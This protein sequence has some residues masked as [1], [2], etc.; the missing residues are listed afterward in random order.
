MNVMNIFIVSLYNFQANWKND[1]KFFTFQIRPKYELVKDENELLIYSVVS[2]RAKQQ[3]VVNSI[4]TGK[5][6]YYS[7]S[8]KVIDFK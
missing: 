2:N 1:L 7:W 5:G 6:V 4:L 3:D 8:I